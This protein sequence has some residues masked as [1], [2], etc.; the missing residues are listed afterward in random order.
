MQYPAQ[1]F[2]LNDINW[3]L[4]K[5]SLDIKSDERKK[6]TTSFVPTDNCPMEAAIQYRVLLSSCV[7]CQI[8]PPTVTRHVSAGWG[9]K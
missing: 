8:S 5:K 1:N 7:G 2:P 3:L 6:T 9:N 4:A